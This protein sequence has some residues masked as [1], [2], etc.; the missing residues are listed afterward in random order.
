MYL[1]EV[2]IYWIN[3]KNYRLYTELCLD[4]IY[5]YNLKVDRLTIPL[6]IRAEPNTVFRKPN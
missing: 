6:Q 5:I 4:E 1:Q 2:T 3:S